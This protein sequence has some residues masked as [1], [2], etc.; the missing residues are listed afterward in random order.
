M[1][2][3]YGKNF[4]TGTR[5]KKAELVGKIEKDNNLVENGV[6]G[7]YKIFVQDSIHRV[8]K[9]VEVDKLAGRLEHKKI[10]TGVA[11]VVGIGSYRKRTMR[12]LGLDTSSCILL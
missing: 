6:V 12:I 7:I 8:D 3:S 2:M 10:A 11:W 5:D 9:S 4:V 1:D